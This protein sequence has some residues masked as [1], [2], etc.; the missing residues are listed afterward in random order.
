M[1]RDI[2]AVPLRALF[3]VEC[4]EFAMSLVCPAV[5]TS[6]NAPTWHATHLPECR[7]GELGAVLV[8]RTGV[9]HVATRCSTL[10]HSAQCRIATQHAATQ[11]SNAA[12][13]AWWQTWR[14]GLR[15]SS[16]SSSSKSPMWYDT[17]LP[18]PLHAMRPHTHRHRQRRAVAAACDGLHLVATGCNGLHLVATG[19][20][21][22]HRVA[23]SCFA[24]RGTSWAR[25]S[26]SSP[27]TTSP[28]R[29]ASS[30]AWSA[31]TRSTRR[32]VC[33]RARALVCA[34]CA[35]RVRANS[36]VGRLSCLISG[37]LGYASGGTARAVQPHHMVA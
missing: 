32:H 22:L 26:P 10:Q 23:T 35:L 5:H 27:T 33:V 11:R 24:G 30:L 13:H 6:Y 31:R 3:L 29:R 15:P 12:Q 16:S 9:K 4:Q 36:W 34:L 17:W 1:R 7:P 21:G 28:H 20:N 2:Q 8:L 19:C 18:H 25:S 14:S 37:E